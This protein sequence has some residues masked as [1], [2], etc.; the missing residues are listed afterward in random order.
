MI[1]E[2]ADSATT[3]AEN[4]IS[5]ADFLNANMKALQSVV[6]EQVKNNDALNYAVNSIHEGFGKVR[7]SST[8][9]NHS[10]DKFTAVKKEVESLREATEKIMAITGPVTISQGKQT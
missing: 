3:G 8:N 10:M 7:T 1:N 2:V 9:L 4:T 5:V 6:D